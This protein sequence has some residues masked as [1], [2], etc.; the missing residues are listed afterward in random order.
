MKGLTMNIPATSAVLMITAQLGFS[1]GFANLD[2]E[3]TTIMTNVN[4]GGDTYTATIPG[5]SVNNPN[6]SLTGTV[7]YDSVALDSSEV[8]LEGANDP[9]G[10]SAIQGMYSIFLQGGTIYAPN[11]NGASIWQTAQI[12]ATAQSIIYWGGPLDV[13]FGGHMLT[14]VDVSNAMNYSVYEADIAPYAG[15]TGEL[16]FTEP[17]QNSGLLDNIQ[18]STS[19][20]P[21]PGA[22]AL[23]AL[24]G[25]SLAWRLRKKSLA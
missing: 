16:L 4:P 13:T 22:L 5:W 17:W 18:F 23:C 8:S 2:F 1:Q 24:G 7:P 14:F 12:P 9:Y 25:L 19:P 10:P 6:F 20:V 15:Q 21:E 11:T 3:S